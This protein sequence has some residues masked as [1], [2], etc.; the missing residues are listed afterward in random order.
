MSIVLPPCDDCG[1][2]TETAYKLRAIY[3]YSDHLPC[4]PPSVNGDMNYANLY[5]P[6][7]LPYGSWGWYGYGNSQ[8]GATNNI[9]GLPDDVWLNFEKFNGG[10]LSAL[11]W[12]L[13]SCGSVSD[14][15]YTSKWDRSTLTVP[16]NPQ[17]YLDPIITVQSDA[18]EL[19]AD[20]FDTV[21][22][23][24]TFAYVGSIKR[25]SVNTSGTFS[26]A[27]EDQTYPTATNYGT[28]VFG[29]WWHQ[30]AVENFS[31][32]PLKYYKRKVEIELIDESYVY[33]WKVEAG[34]TYV[35]SAD[36]P[37]WC[38]KPSG[39]DIFS[40]TIDGPGG[41]IVET[42][43]D[44]ERADPS[45]YSTYYADTTSQT[46]PAGTRLRFNMP[47]EGERYAFNCNDGATSGCP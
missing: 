35:M 2:A 17:C 1:G 15:K 6:A 3:H 34:G 46:F 33:V 9:N 44:V 32:L 40:P 16:G 41:L 4:M 25:H 23:P 38:I 10:T 45:D 24:S 12:T 22:W 5:G 37:H 18:V 11:F 19:I 29:S 27:T 31:D 42:V 13:F 28:R 47:E 21:S 26:T 14:A 39:D 30:D 43:W 7:R 20:D 8:W 36:I